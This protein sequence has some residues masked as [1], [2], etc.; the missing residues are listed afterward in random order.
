MI[1]TKQVEE[2]Q[3]SYFKSICKEVSTLSIVDTYTLPSARKLNREGKS[4]ESFKPGSNRV[5]ITN[6]RPARTNLTYPN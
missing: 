3:A 1:N 2:V 6:I 5:L 4:A